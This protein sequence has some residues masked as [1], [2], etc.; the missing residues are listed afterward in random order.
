MALRP[1]A[2]RAGH[3][4]L[5][6]V[7]VALV[8]AAA[9]LLGAQAQAAEEDSDP[10][11][12]VIDPA[13]L[14]DPATVAD[15]AELFRV[16]CVSCHGPGGVGSPRGP[17]LTGAGAASAHFYLTTGR[18]PHTG[19]SDEQAIRKPP[20]HSPEEIEAL[21]AYV[22]SLGEGQAIPH[23][24]LAEGNLQEGGDLFRGECAAC[25]SATGAGGALSFGQN[26][27]SL[28][29]ATPVQVYEAM[30]VGPG[31]MPVF[32]PTAFTEEEL[33]S[34]VL[35]VETLQNLGD[36]GGFSLGRVGPIPEGFVAV[37]VGTGGLMLVVFLIGRRRTGEAEPASQ[38]V[39]PADTVG[40]GR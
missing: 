25:H 7:A 34:I 16:G 15:G 1:P 4:R 39:R 36:P 22:A 3:L 6:P 31:Q 27:P 35:Y 17:G 9:G 11:G 23:V 5:L 2:L 8:V 28:D 21:V 19:A 38:P 26:A 18:M 29:E 20:A 32:S 37:A 33:N 13:A 14:D 40:A 24:D 30:L 12:Y 10:L